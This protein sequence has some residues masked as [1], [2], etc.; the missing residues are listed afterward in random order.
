M[1]STEGNWKLLYSPNISK[2]IIRISLGCEFAVHI[3]R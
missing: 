2:K 3:L 1:K